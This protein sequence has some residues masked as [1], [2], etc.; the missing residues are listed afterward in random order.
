MRIEQRIWNA[1]QGWQWKEE[2]QLKDSAQLVLA[3]GEKTIVEDRLHYETIKQFYPKAEIV[4]CSTAGEIHDTLIDD[5]SLVLTAV[6]FE[7]TRIKTTKISTQVVKNSRE[8]GKELSHRLSAEDLVYILVLLTDGKTISA[9]ELIAGMSEVLDPQVVVSGGL[10][11]N[12]ENLEETLV[13]L[14]TVL[15]NNLVV[16]IGFYGDALQVGNGAMGGWDPFGP[17]RL[18][19]KAQGNVVY[20]LDKKSILALYKK[21][22]GEQAKDLPKS[23]FFFPLKMV[24]AEEKNSV[25]RTVIGIDEENQSMTFAGNIPEGARVTLM[26]GNFDRLIDASAEAAKHSQQAVGMEFAHLAIIISSIGRK[27]VLGPRVEEELEEV[28][29]VLGEN[30]VLCGFYSYGQI[31]SS[32]DFKVTRLQNQVMTITTFSE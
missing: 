12:T 17:E 19:T 1:E 8:I 31:S 9:S 2:K 24:I 29:Y 10:A 4:F 22:L 23:G 21:Y 27:F 32:A 7:K 20:E 16:A 26:K 18:V 28:Q 6:Q 5:H 3:F 13:G 14:N 11:V 25:V 15:S 30:C